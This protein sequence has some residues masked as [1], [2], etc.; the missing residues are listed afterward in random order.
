MKIIHIA[1]KNYRSL[2]LFD[3]DVDDY[4]ALIGAN[5]SGKSCALYA[6]DWFFNG[7]PLSA[8]DVTGNS[9]VGE[10]GPATEQNQTI[11]VTVTFGSLTV[12]DK[13]RL[14]EYGRGATARFR[15][16]WR[17]GD[18]KSKV[19]GNATQGPGFADV[20]G[21]T[22]V[23]EFR[24]AYVRLRS[25]FS[26]LPDLGSAPSKDQ[27]HAAL[28]E[29]ESKPENVQH[30]VTVSD[31]DATHMFGINGPNVIKDC[32]RIILV[33]AAADI[34]SQVGTSG[35]GSA[36]NELIGSLMTK[37][38]AETRTKWLT[39]NADKFEE[40][41]SLVRESIETSTGMQADRINER[42]AGLVPNAS[43]IFTPTVPEFVPRSDATV[44]TDVSI[45]GLTNDVSRQGHGVQRA[46][47]IAMFQS[48]VPD[49]AYARQ[50][51]Q[52]EEGETPEEAADRL[53]AE[54]ENLPV[55]L[56]CIEE[57]EIYQ[58]P[59]RARAFARILAELASQP[60]A[61]VIIAT[62][63]PYFVRPDQF[64]SLRRFRLSSG[65]TNVTQTDTSKVSAAASCSEPQVKKFVEKQLPAT[66][67][68]GFFCDAV[69]LVE[70]GTDKVVLE[71][72]AEKLGMPLD[73]KGI[74]VL[75]M[76]GKSGLRIP[77]EMFMKLSIPVY[78]VVDG[79]AL[80]AA[81]KYPSNVAARARAH[82]S[83]KGDTERVLGWL[84]ASSVKHGSLPYAFGNASTVAGHFTVWEDDIEEE[85]SKWP[86]FGAALA[87]N[88]GV[89]RSKDLL[90]Y[91]TGV[92]EGD[93]ADLP[94]VLR[95][96]VEAIAA[97]TG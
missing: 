66:F 51:H 60:T 43:V 19:V 74:S 91:R 62:H 23:A 29:W 72:L 85:L 4:T 95:S 96:W 61:Q 54:L 21:F 47:M 41:N 48:L 37:A 63:S 67:S 3:I 24:P 40:L 75:E 46:V 28:A 89:L 78:V 57:P 26:D 33:P 9:H 65:E 52:P 59:I 13:E 15:R 69:A 55:L 25:R 86:S 39:E 77:Y 53:R 34:A 30:L 14:K 83:H 2:K 31:A 1:V 42:L 80:G 73:S 82:A 64:S 92:L 12:R 50:M 7:L 87:T 93:I 18:D 56:V 20:R 58:H 11:E 81:R 97:F 71:A 38:S 88:G 16:S 17:L 44:V 84:P 49:E 10:E 22:R 36:L 68:E 27:V 94:M 35:K 90:V 45:D 76:S 5:G 70:G 79:D 8:T 32:M 6:L